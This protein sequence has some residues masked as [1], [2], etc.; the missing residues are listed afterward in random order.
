MLGTSLVVQA[1][2]KGKQKY[3]WKGLI[4]AGAL[5]FFGQRAVKKRLK[6]RSA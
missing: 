5:A 4:A 1:A 6:R 3:G 2:K